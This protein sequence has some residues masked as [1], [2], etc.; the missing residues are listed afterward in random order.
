MDMLLYVKLSLVMGLEYAIWGS[1]MPVLAARLLGPL[2][3]TGKQ[4]GWIY[5]TLPLA[6]IISPLIAG[7]VADKWVNAEWILVVF[8]LIGACLL[9]LAATRE[10]FSSLLVA[11]LLWSVFFAGTLP[12]VNAILFSK[13]SD[14]YWIGWVFFWAPAGWAL[15]GYFLTGIRQLF[16]T[17]ERGRDCLFLS[18]VLS[19]I[20]A[21]CCLLLPQTPAAGTGGT[22]ILEALAMLKSGNF[23]V[24][25]VVSLVVAGLMQFYFVGSAQLMI[26][27]G[28]KAKYISAVMA[29]AQVV[30]AVAT[31]MLMQ[32]LIDAA[33]YKWTLIIGAACWMT[34]Y[35]VYVLGKPRSLI[36]ISQS[37]HG[38]AYVLFII[39]GQK[40][41]NSL[42]REEIINSVQAIIFAATTG[43]GM[44]F[45]THFAGIVMDKFK[46]QDKFQWRPV[47][48]VP[49]VI[50]LVSVLVLAVF[51]K[52]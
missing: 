26:D 45:G 44:F 47:F 14:G 20:M 37:L 21:G 32:R 49:A 5:A 12:I 35:F 8:H 27:S 23:L 11:M 24:F 25:V 1:W 41:A 40:F 28:I 13:V 52:G 50:T 33:G 29:I 43:V 51:L 17:A 48:A 16:K 9:F 4:T 39:V 38:F 6:C 36:I 42:A 10:K 22:P 31:F 2:K 7:Q 19:I 3:F 15:A 18:A 30:Q 34:L 46:K